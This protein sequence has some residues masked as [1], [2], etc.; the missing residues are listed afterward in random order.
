MSSEKINPSELITQI[1]TLSPEPGQF[2]A[3]SPK[4]SEQQSKKPERPGY[5]FLI[6]GDKAEKFEKGQKIIYRGKRTNSGTIKDFMRDE[7]GNITGMEVQGKGLKTSR[8]ITKEEFIEW[9]RLETS[10]SETIVSEADET[11]AIGEKQQIEEKKE[12]GEMSKTLLSLNEEKKKIEEQIFKETDENAKKGLLAKKREICEGIIKI[13]SGRDGKDIEKEIKEEEQ[14]QFEIS[15]ASMGKTE[16]D[17]KKNI[18]DRYYNEI[19]QG[20]GLSEEQKKLLAKEGE[21]V[22]SNWP[23]T[24]ILDKEEVATCI[25]TAIDPLR[26]KRAGLFG[27]S[28]K[29][30]TIG[31]TINEKTG[32]EEKGPVGAENIDDFKKRLETS[33]GRAVMEAEIQ[34]KIEQ[35]KK[36]IIDKGIT[37]FVL[38]KKVI[39]IIDSAEAEDADKKWEAGAPE[40]FEQPEESYNLIIKPPVKKKNEEAKKESAGAY[41]KVFDYFSTINNNLWENLKKE[42]EKHSGR[43]GSYKWQSLEKGLLKTAKILKDL[44]EGNTDSARGE[45]EKMIKRTEKM[46]VKAHKNNDKKELALLSEKQAELESYLEYLQEH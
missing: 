13:A 24:I 42:K 1:D 32:K 2:A 33:Q 46:A 8:K 29:I 3:E 30:V 4:P 20:S 41:E 6:L 26:V 10:E 9:Q 44:D 22:V 12:A 35:R 14:R 25:K 28:K 43:L 36:E 5:D 15:L 40:F 27:F 23:S 16:E 31:P 19:I 18:R 37:D 38:D 17:Y 21:I 11:V 34:Q 39:E 7:N 45:L